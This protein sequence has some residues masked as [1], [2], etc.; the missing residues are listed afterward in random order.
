MKIL[1]NKQE[2]KIILSGNTFNLK[3]KIKIIGGKW[4]PLAKN[5][6]LFLTNENLENLKKLGLSI[7]DHFDINNLESPA[8]PTDSY[9]VTN[10]LLFINNIITKN[11]FHNYWISGE[12]SNLKQSNE[13]LFFDLID[14]EQASSN[15]NKT[16]S[17]P[18]IIW[19]NVRKRLDSKLNQILFSDGTKIKILIRC[20][21]RKEGAKIIGIIEDIDIHFTQGELALQRLAIVQSL[22]NKGLYHKNKN[23]SFPS[24][25]LKIALITAKDSRAYSD[26]INELSLSKI[27]FKITLFDCNMQGEK[28]AENIVSAFQIVAKNTFFYDC[29]VITRGGGS[30]LDL[31]WFDD[32]SIA[33]Q[34]A[35]CPLPVLTAIGH[36]DDNSI[37][38]EVANIS[39]KTPTAAARI[40]TDTVLHS[41]QFFFQK[42]DN[43]TYFLL[44]RLAKEKNFILSL[45]E[46]C[47]SSALKRIQSEQKNLKNIE[48]MLKIIKSSIE[49]NLQRGFAL[50]YDDVNN[51]LQGKHFLSP[52]YSKNLKL[53]FAGDCENHYIFVEVL[54]KAVSES[55]E[56]TELDF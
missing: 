14:K 33:E 10:F 7:E 49:Q 19:V 46:K 17:I 45:Q 50:V 39:E 34:I 43:I 5:W 44:K 12:I 25:P 6:W 18:C 42:V 27:A 4:D 22:K 53:K 32:F 23:I 15:F 29:V 40:L 11:L 9:S 36:F 21:F 56:S 20:E 24:Y 48:K 54:V 13:H 1:L 37:A 55:R 52:T 51:L 35:L 30:R 38:D 28:T 26:F 2:K 31:R 41:Y 47:T 8:I 16:A 3:E